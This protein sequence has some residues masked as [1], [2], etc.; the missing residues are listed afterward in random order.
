MTGI[1]NLIEKYEL[2]GK[3]IAFFDIYDPIPVNSGGDWYR[4]QILGDLSE[5]NEVTEYYTKYIPEK[6]GYY[7]P[8]IK[9]KRKF[10]ENGKIWTKLW[11][12]LSDKMGMIKPDLL[13]N[14]SYINNIEADIVFT[15]A[16]CYHIGKYVS[17]INNNAPI[18]FVMHNIEWKYLKNIKSPFYIP[19]KFYENH[20][21]AN[22]DGI[23]SISTNE[24]EYASNYITNDK[25]FHVP[26]K[27]YSLFT[28]KGE[29]YNY[30]ADK[31][32][33]LFYG[34][35]DREQNIDAV[36]FI[37]NKLIPIM[38]KEKIMEKV[39]VNIFGSGDPPKFL[40]LKDDKDINFLGTVDDPSKY[41]RGA[42]LVL[43]PLKNSAGIKI[44]IIEALGCHKPI[45]ATPEAAENLSNELKERIHI[46]NDSR[47]FMDL[48]KASITPET[49]DPFVFT[50][51]ANDSFV[52]NSISDRK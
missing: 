8:D 52:F 37:K 5:N 3:K 19:M 24:A 42:D 43:V 33:L 23:I 26:P 45:I 14:K 17:K 27:T 2:Q 31:F 7:P 36:K 25:I 16:E 10:L 9:F 35:L 18:I 46:K 13:F 44:R 28:P 11:N 40:D 51:E 29:K 47:G 49:N 30:G 38:K 41:I 39:R 20:I 15:I 50:P 21:M 6:K 12:I 32:N 22:V 48:I 34:S 4:H 1:Q